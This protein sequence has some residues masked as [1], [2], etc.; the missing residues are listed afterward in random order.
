MTIASH[1]LAN[2][3]CNEEPVKI[4]PKTDP[5]ECPEP[6]ESIRDPVIRLTRQHPGGVRRIEDAS[7]RPPHPEEGMLCEGGSSENM[8][9]FMQGFA[10]YACER[11]HAIECRFACE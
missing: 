5:G 6:P 7:A 10:W 1:S 8:Q 11:L 2:H 3:L 9:D 4:H